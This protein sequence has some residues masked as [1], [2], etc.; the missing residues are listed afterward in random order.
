LSADSFGN[1][2]AG[3][4]GRR[5]MIK[6]EDLFREENAA[7]DF[8][9]SFEI[10]Y[11]TKEEYERVGKILHEGLRLG[12]EASADAAP[13]QAEKTPR[14]TEERLRSVTERMPVMMDAF[15]E[16][17][18]IIFWNRECERVTGFSSERDCGKSEGHEFTLPRRILPVKDVGRAEE[19]R[20]RLL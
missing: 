14:A 13:K 11:P 3:A 10:L 12:I 6:L 20:F 2:S 7:N 9:T 8:G 16:Q 17:G 18:T 1:E 4:K 5:P 19:A 15:D